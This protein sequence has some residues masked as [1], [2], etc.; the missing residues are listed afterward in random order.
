MKTLA[1]KATQHNVI[2][3]TKQAYRVTS[4]SS[5]SKYTVRFGRTATCT[6]LYMQ[7]N[8]SKQCSHIMAAKPKYAAATATPAPQRNRRDFS[9]L[10]GFA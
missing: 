6:C 5:G 2:A 9:D 8:P 10:F 1:Q 7:F 3:L 4:A